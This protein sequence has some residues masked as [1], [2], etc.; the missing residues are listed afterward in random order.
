MSSDKNSSERFRL[1]TSATHFLSPSPAHLPVF[2][3]KQT[4]PFR[5]S[6]TLWKGDEQTNE[7]SDDAQT[8]N[9][10]TETPPHF[11][12]NLHGLCLCHKQNPALHV[13][14]APLSAPSRRAALALPASL[15][16]N[17]ARPPGLRG[18]WVHTCC[19][20]LP[21]GVAFYSQSIPIWIIRLLLS[22]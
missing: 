5:H 13:A 16:V 21:T 7:G 4:S 17:T 10:G 18:V 19:P 20:G 2:N 6:V 9:P 11:P 8:P 12:T 22:R 1:E 14:P 15:V 3:T